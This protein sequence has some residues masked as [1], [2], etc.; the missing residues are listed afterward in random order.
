MVP[1]GRLK[2][3]QSRL[4]FL[5]CGTVDQQQPDAEADQRSGRE[6]GERKPEARR[7]IGHWPLLAC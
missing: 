3:V 6:H 4:S 2:C 7:Q 5:S 1:S